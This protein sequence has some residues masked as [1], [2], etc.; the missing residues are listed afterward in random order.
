ME[1]QPMRQ[2]LDQIPESAA[3]IIFGASGDLTHRKL[4]PALYSLHRKGRLPKSFSIIGQARREWDHDTFRQE[5]RQAVEAHGDEPPD[6]ASWDPFAKRLFYCR[7]DVTS[8]EAY[9]DLEALL[10][11]LQNDGFETH[12]RVYYLSIGPKFYAEIVDHLAQAGMIAEDDGWRRLVVEKPFGV[13]LKSAQELN[14]RLH[15]CFREDQ[16]YRIDHYLGKETAQNILFFRFANAVFEPIWNRRYIDHIQISV[17]EE[18]DVGERAGYYDQ[19]GVLRDMVQNH[20]LQL[21]CLV[22]MEPPSSFAAD[23]LRGEKVKVL[24][25]IRPVELQDTVRAQYQGYCQTP[26]VAPDS[27]M[28]TYGALKLFIENWRWQGTPFYLRSGKALARK[29]SEITVVFHGPPCAMFNFPRDFAVTPNTLSICIQPNE[30]IHLKFEAKVPDTTQET[31][32]VNMDFLYRDSFEG[33]ELP[34]AYERLLLDVM[35]GD[36]ALFTRDDEVEAAWRLIDP[37]VAGWQTPEAPPLSSY[38]PG[39]WGPPEAV[40]LLRRDSRDWLLECGQPTEQ[41]G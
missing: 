32:S 21:L 18:V 41:P 7:G 10:N 31:R 15:Q 33:V 17:L 11:Q 36:A 30:G 25:A 27:R 6:E 22:A 2:Q 35:E 24:E 3:I 28:A 40:E 19:A 14:R 12:N 5:M 9:Q 13:D 16:V 8:D 23:A 34:P 29:T 4:L 37:V 20:L 1:A 39:S 26:N 38:E